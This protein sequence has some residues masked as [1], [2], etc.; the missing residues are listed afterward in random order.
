MLNFSPD[1]TDERTL[2]VN[3]RAIERHLNDDHYVRRF[4][5]GQFVLAGA[6]A[7]TLVLATA[8]APHWPVIAMVDAATSIASVSFDKP[9]EWRAG[10]M[11]VRYWY[12]S[13]VG[14]T[15]AFRI[16]VAMQAVRGGEALIGTTLVGAAASVAGPAVAHTVIRAADVYTTTALGGDDELFSLRLIRL[17]ADGADTNTNDFYLLYARVEHIPAQQVSQ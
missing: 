5:P 12:T 1:R 17:G 2:Q 4:T 11:A 16:Q 3:Q 7:P 8:A 6:G 13:P 9:S 15:N 14:S 10:H